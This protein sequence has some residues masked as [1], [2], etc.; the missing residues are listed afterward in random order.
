MEPSA[1]GFEDALKRDVQDR[2]TMGVSNK[3]INVAELNSQLIAVRA[4]TL[5]N[6]DALPIGQEFNASR[7]L[8]TVSV[9][10][11]SQKVKNQYIT[12]CQALAMLGFVVLS[13]DKTVRE[14]T[15]TTKEKFFKITR[16]P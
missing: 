8:D 12:I 11:K 7:E 13:R 1:K 14:G 5:I 2:S 10:V 16:M 6:V 4:S 15:K 3:T 9:Y